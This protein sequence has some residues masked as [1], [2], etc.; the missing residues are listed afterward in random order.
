MDATDLLQCKNVGVGINEVQRSVL[1]RVEYE[2][3]FKVM[4]HQES[5]WILVQ[6]LR[7]RPHGKFLNHVEVCQDGSGI[8]EIVRS[9]TC[10]LRVQGGRGGTPE[11]SCENMPSP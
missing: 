9:K 2:K 8:P 3:T 7:A 1:R 10:H 11:F 5:I 4:Q 6:T